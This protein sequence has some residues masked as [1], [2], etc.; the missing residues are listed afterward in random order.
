M[1]LIYPRKLKE[2]LTRMSMT[3]SQ[4]G[5]G[6]WREASN[7]KEEIAKIK[8]DMEIVWKEYTVGSVLV[9]EWILA[10]NSSSSKSLSRHMRACTI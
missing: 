9:R 4:T 1:N 8:E 6:R 5:I 2:M 3:S 10:Y 7:D